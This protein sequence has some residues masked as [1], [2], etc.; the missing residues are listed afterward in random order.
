MEEAETLCQRIG[1]MAK[2]ALRCLGNPLRLKDLY[3]TGFKIFVNIKPNM[4]SNAS[5]YI[6]SLLPPGI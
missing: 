3:G 4:S 2:G 5:S 6:E 1:I